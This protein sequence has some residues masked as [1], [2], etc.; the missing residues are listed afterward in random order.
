MDVE[1][2]S[3]VCGYVIVGGLLFLCF[4]KNFYFMVAILTYCFFLSF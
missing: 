4:K 2:F 1:I 3:I